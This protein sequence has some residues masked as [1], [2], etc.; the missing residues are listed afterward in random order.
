MKILVQKVARAQVTVESSVVGEIGAG[1]VVFLGITHD[2]SIEK[3]VWLANKCVHLRIFA[4]GEG[5]ANHSL[6]EQKGAAL[7]VSQF[8]LYADCNKGKRPSFVQAASPEI[9]K[10]LYDRF[11]EEIGRFGIDVSTGLFGAKMEVCLVNDGPMT[12]LLER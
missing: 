3:A 8:T 4:D 9:A 2:D 7:I 10:P 1:V 6:L 5:R 12:F 11:V